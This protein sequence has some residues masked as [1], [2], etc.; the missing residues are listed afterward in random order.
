MTNMLVRNDPKITPNF[1]TQR[2]SASKNKARDSLGSGTLWE[3]HLCDTFPRWVGQGWGGSGGEQNRTQTLQGHTAL[4]AV[5][6]QQIFKSLFPF[7]CLSKSN[8]FLGEIFLRNLRNVEKKRKS[9]NGK[10]FTVL[11]LGSSKFRC[12][13]A[14]VVMRSLGQ[15][16]LFCPFHKAFY[17]QTMD[18]RKIGTTHTLQW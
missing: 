6:S 17:K 14:K 15:T 13:K 16:F 1:Y 5:K 18:T 9:K 11:W 2:E 10:E 3:I 4:K 8:Y 7:C 12:S